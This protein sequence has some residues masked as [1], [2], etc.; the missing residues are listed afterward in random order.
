MSIKVRQLLQASLEEELQNLPDIE[1]ENEESVVELVQ[2]KQ[3]AESNSDYLD[4]ANDV[5]DEV[6]DIKEA[7]E[8]VNEKGGISQE[9]LVFFNLAIER[10]CRKIG[11]ERPRQFPTME[12]FGKDKRV[13]ISIEELEDIAN[14]VDQGINQLKSGSKE[15]L[16]RLLE[17]L[18]VSVPEAHKKIER[19]IDRAKM[20]INNTE[21]PDTSNMLVAFGDGLNIAL[22]V[23]GQTP[24]NLTSYLGNYVQ[25]G[26]ALCGDYARVAINNGLKTTGLPDLFTYSDAN[27][28]NK[29]IEDAVCGMEDPRN[30][31]TTDQKAL[32]L[33]STQSLFV[34]EDAAPAPESSDVEDT[35]DE[36]ETTEDTV[37]SEDGQPVVNEDKPNPKIEWIK[38]FINCCPVNSQVHNPKQVKVLA[39][40]QPGFGYRALSLD[41]TISIARQFNKLYCDLNLSEIIERNQTLAKDSFETI[42]QLHDRFKSAEEKIQV[43]IEA[44]FNLLLQFVE[45]VFKLAHW[46]VLNYLTNLVLTT[47]AF[48]L[49]AERSIALPE[50]AVEPVQETE[51]EPEPEEETDEPLEEGDGV[52][53]DADL[54]ADEDAEADNEETEDSTDEDVDDSDSEENEA[55]GEE[56]DSEELE[57]D[58]NEED[59]SE[60]PPSKDETEEENE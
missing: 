32:V 44:T 41:D 28:F 48:V 22:S 38:K 21:R 24:E 56:D 42:E 45:A 58:E 27:S 2:A 5:K 23:D 29:T 10:I 8:V 40:E 47:N 33:P 31:L 17:A 12:S 46:P 43:E 54:E 59:S 49:Y 60:E 34:V 6:T 11:I 1:N 9:A 30:H 16:M 25:L 18:C 37:S 3:E 13:K 15:S 39:E 20:A 26:Q 57:E 52:E 14:R 35:V 50:G 19:L 7:A 53:E 36:S 51:P 55:D 4:Q